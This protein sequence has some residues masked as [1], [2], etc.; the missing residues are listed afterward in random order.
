[1]CGEFMAYLLL[2]LTVL[3]WAGNFV[4]ARSMVDV[5][6]PFTMASL[7]WSLAFLILLP[8]AY[9]SLIKERKQILKHWKVV[10][11]LSMFGVA[12]FNS[13]IY[14]GVQTTTATNAALLQS[15][16]PILV[17]I[18]G[19]VFY[20]DFLSRKQLVGVCSSCVG[21]MVI[22]TEGNLA[23][24]FDLHLNQGDL[25][26]L[27]GVS[28]WT[29]YTV[30]LRYKPAEI[31][32]LS[33]LST[34]MLVGSLFILPFTLM[35]FSQGKVSAIS[36]NQDIVSSVLYLAIFPSL[37]SY[38]FWNKGVAQ[39]GAAKASLFIHLMPV[40][41]TILA[42]IFLNEKLHLF[43]LAGIVLIFFG[44]YLAVITDI[45]KRIRKSQA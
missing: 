29:V 33:F 6:P 3:F 39:V 38:L 12:M 8:F 27:C 28:S 35:E 23:A 45:L 7:R 42:S 18:L 22:I 20:R 26:I 40:F 14:L 11:V 31:T 1:M 41:G 43:H 24:L 19:A 4:L 36:V 21:V 37:L 25:W 5:L 34:N 9:Q 13:F 10:C 44:I 17:L 32:G 15:A 2:V 16:I 30:L